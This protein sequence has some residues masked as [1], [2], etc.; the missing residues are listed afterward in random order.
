MKQISLADNLV[1]GLLKLQVNSRLIWGSRRHGK[2]QSGREVK[3]MK[4]L[5]SCVKFSEE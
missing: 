1:V 5:Y 2:K 3:I 4:M